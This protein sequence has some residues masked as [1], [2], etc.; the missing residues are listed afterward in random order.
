[1]ISD[2]DVIRAAYELIERYGPNA[3]S[4]A[5]DRIDEFSIIQDQSGVNVAVRVLSA[6]EHRLD[7][8]GMNDA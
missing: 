4:V 6:L 2:A 1:M 8:M 3:M 5:Q 7:S